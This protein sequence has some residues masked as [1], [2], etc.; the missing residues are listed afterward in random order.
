[1]VVI[2]KQEEHYFT[3]TWNHDFFDNPEQV[4]GLSEKIYWKGDNLVFD[5]TER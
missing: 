2:G 1:M 4:E 3:W 5:G